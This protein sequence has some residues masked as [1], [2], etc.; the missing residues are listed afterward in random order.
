MSIAE[1][2]AMSHKH[3][4]IMKKT[5]ILLLAMVMILPLTFTACNQTES[6]ETVVRWEETTYNFD[7]TLADFNSDY[8]GYNSYPV[9]DT[10]YYKDFAMST[11]YEKPSNKDEVLPSKVKGTYEMKITM[12]DEGASTLLVTTQTLFVRYE[13]SVIESSKIADE[14]KTKM[15]SG[16]EDPF[17]DEEDSADYITLKS[18]TDTSVKFVNKAGQ[19]PIESSMVVDGFYIGKSGQQLSK[20]SVSTK[21]DFDKNIATV[22]IND[23]EPVENK[24]KTN[25]KNFIDANQVLL[26][27]RGFE[28]TS[29]KF[30]DSPSVL[31]YSPLENKTY[32]GS[33]AFSYQANCILPNGD[34]NAYVKLNCVNV[35]LDSMP[36]LQQQ[37][38]PSTLV[39][40]GLDCSM[41]NP[42]YTTT[43]F[44]V[45]YL[46]Y[47]L[48]D[49][50]VIS[51]E[52]ISAL[53]TK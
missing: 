5:F 32:T 20:Y 15:V 14:L 11:A 38:L 37:N 36:Y 27:V 47:Q 31:V 19:R 8:S 41:E 39:S 48:N 7:I 2:W 17:A 34:E 10:T 18:T 29:G 49:T 9:G 4:E 40:S 50:S 23:G 26:Y 53:T 33:F 46:A 16:E 1:Q 22:T 43:R 42:K 6:T 30:N 12:P 13:K 21:Y 44:R 25:N 52:V 28:K 24:I 51:A 35:F 45:G 3:G